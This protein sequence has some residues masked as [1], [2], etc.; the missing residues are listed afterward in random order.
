MRLIIL[1]AFIASIVPASLFAALAA[2]LAV[3]AAE[4]AGLEYDS[5]TRSVV[6]IPPGERLLNTARAR[7]FINVDK[8]AH[9]LE[10]ARFA[11]D[12]S[13]YF[14]DV[15]ANRIYRLDPQTRELKLVAEFDD[16]A[17][18]G[19]AFHKDGRL[20]FCGHNPGRNKGEI[21][22]MN[23]DGTNRQMI[24]S[25]EKGFQPN[26]IVF[27]KAGG[28]YFTD[29]KGDMTHPSGGVYY[30]TPDF[31]EVKPVIAN[32][33]NANGV[34]L[35]PDGRTLW[36]GDYGRG[37]LYRVVLE[38]DTGF[39]RIHSTPV[40][41]FTGRGPDSMRTDSDGNLYVAVMSQGRV[42]VFNPRGLPIGQIL[43]PGRDNGKNLY[44]ASLD[45]M[46]NSR[47]IFMVA[48]DDEGAGANIFRS[49]S[50]AQGS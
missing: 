15:S 26:D 11:K 4:S 28:I 17:P 31:R 30:I 10:G 16:F 6:P 5:Q 3:E 2:P 50:Y 34:A 32:I 27:D 42:L 38:G 21:H 13:L 25:H 29:F 35:S 33:A 44:V 1:T 14:C 39:N 37:I 22:A 43:L 48:R 12:G 18:T 47:D 23:P 36:I 45:I 40:Y 20:F 9:T 41:Y 46:P 24:L 8:A 49:L 7:H 19:I